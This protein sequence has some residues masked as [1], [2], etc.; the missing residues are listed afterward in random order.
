MSRPVHPDLIEYMKSLDI[1]VLAKRLKSE[2]SI[3]D[4]GLFLIRV[5]HHV[6]VTGLSAGMTLKDLAVIFAR[7]GDDEDIPSRL[8][9]AIEE[10]EDNAFRTI[11]A[12]SN[13]SKAYSPSST[14][15]SSDEK[16]SVRSISSGST[17]TPSL[18]EPFLNLPRPPLASSSSFNHL[19]MTRNHFSSS[20]L[21]SNCSEDFN[22]IPIPSIG[23]RGKSWCPSIG[24][25]D[26]IA[27]T[28]ERGMSCSSTSISDCDSGPSSFDPKSSMID[29]LLKSQSFHEGLDVEALDTLK[30]PTPSASA[31][32]NASPP[33]KS[34]SRSAQFEEHVTLSS[35]LH[36]SLSGTPLKSLKT[37]DYHGG[38]FQHQPS[39]RYPHNIHPGTQLMRSEAIQIP[40]TAPVSSF[41]LTDNSPKSLA[42]FPYGSPHGY[43]VTSRTL[44]ASSVVVEDDYVMCNLGEFPEDFQSAVTSV[45]ENYADILFDVPLSASIPLSRVVSFS[46]FESRPLYS[47]P[48]LRGM[49]N[50]RLERRK[51]MADSAEF[52]QLRLDFALNRVTGIIHRIVTQQR[53]LSVR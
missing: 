38:V 10:A 4:D 31:F 20:S 30:Q 46:G 25:L 37:V 11:E 43:P 50:I 9:Q 7:S 40:N 42:C 18:D 35:P 53:D 21:S 6:L 45:E 28:R 33:V 22:N 16:S 34:L 41:P 13:R 8:E 29:M 48:S 36:N 32:S 23:S 3:S 51:A 1:E 27:E 15:G 49:G 12:K 2:A 14:F 26:T 19:S 52:Q 5:A 24:Q 47:N 44:E 39:G 17:D